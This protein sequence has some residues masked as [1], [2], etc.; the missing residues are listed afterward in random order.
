MDGPILCCPDTPANPIEF[1]KGGS[2]RCATTGYPMVRALVACG[3]RPIIDA[4]F[5]TDRTHE[6]GYAHH[7]LGSTRPG[8]IV[9]A[10]RNCRGR[11]LDHRAGRHR[12]LHR[13]RRADH[14]VARGLTRPAVADRPGS[15]H[16]VTGGR[17]RCEELRGRAG[18]PCRP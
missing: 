12:L 3:T 2:S 1:S 18:R 6:L 10:D 8:M 13:R 14:P 17:V 4:V 9:L 11:H 7:L 15:S 16:A 5:G